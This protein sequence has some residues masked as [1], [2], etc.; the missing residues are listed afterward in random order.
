MYETGHFAT[1]WQNMRLKLGLQPEFIASDWRSGA[2]ADAIEARLREDKGHTIKAVCVVHNETSTGATSRIDEVRARHRRGQASGAADGGH[3]LLARLHRLPPRRVGRGRHRRRLAEGADAAAGLGFNAVSERRWPPRKA[4]KLPKS[5]FA[6]EEMLPA[7]KEGFFPYTP[8]TNLLYG[9]AEAIDMLH[10]EGLERVFARHDRH[11]EGVRRAVQGVGPR[12]SVQ[13]AKVLF[14][15][16]DRDPVA[17]RARRRRLPQ[18]G[19]R[20]LRRVARHRPQQ[21]RRQGVPH[22]PSRRHQ[23]PHHARR[24]GRRG[25]G[26]CPCRR[27][28]QARRRARGDGLFHRDG[29]GRHKLCRRRRGRAARKTAKA[30]SQQEPARDRT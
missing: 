21:S 1:L 19:A 13:G 5:Y 24:A 3:D 17:G 2:D 4:A 28:A 29:R 25:N 20:A 18:D 16:A 27:A 6:W 9:L 7:N 12:D 30:A 8:A 23:R 10:E 26:A 15:R 14:L 22:R 11:A